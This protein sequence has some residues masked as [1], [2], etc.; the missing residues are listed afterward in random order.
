MLQ[1][2]KLQCHLFNMCFVV[3]LLFFSPERETSFLFR[4]NVIQNI[5]N[6]DGNDDDSSTTFI[7]LQVGPC[8]IYI[9]NISI[10]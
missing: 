9:A 3:V 5:N 8:I 10:F 1:K 4:H 2:A 7:N 6:N